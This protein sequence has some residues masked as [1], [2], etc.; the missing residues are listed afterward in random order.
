MIQPLAGG[1]NCIQ[2]FTSTT[3]WYLDP[4][5]SRHFGLPEQEK[6][7]KYNLNE[8]CIPLRWASPCWACWLTDMVTQTLIGMEPSLMGLFT[9]VHFLLTQ[10]KKCAVKRAYRW[11]NTGNSMD[12][13]THALPPWHYLDITL[14]SCW[15]PRNC[16]NSDQT[17]IWMS[18]LLQAVL[19]PHTLSYI[20]W[21]CQVSEDVSDTYNPRL[22][23]NVHVKEKPTHV[24]AG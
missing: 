4:F 22:C 8:G 15:W 17:Y 10:A 1:Y 21:I 24:R 7:V 2:P 6:Q 14:R 13:F 18:R 23:T 5:H 20:K 3:A 19:R 12:R 9:P 11:N 16:P